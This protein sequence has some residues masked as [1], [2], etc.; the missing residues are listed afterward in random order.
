M[1]V[2]TDRLYSRQQVPG[3]VRL[4]HE[5][6][7]PC[8]QSLTDD[9]IG[10]GYRQHDYFDLRIGLRELTC[11]SQSIEIWHSNIEDHDIGF[12]ELRLFDGFAAIT[13]CGRIRMLSG[14]SRKPWL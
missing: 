14:I 5:P 4:Q 10:V 1:F 12:Q 9:M 2:L 7:G 8:V 3:R 6:P 13:S 11:C